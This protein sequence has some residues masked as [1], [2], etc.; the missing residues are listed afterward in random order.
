MNI[1]VDPSKIKGPYQL[2]TVFLIAVESILGYWMIRI[3]DD[4]SSERIVPGI[5]VTIIFIIFLIIT[6]KIRQTDSNGKTTHYP[7]VN[8]KF[9]ISN[10]T[11]NLDSERCT[12]KIRKADGED[13]S[14]LANPV[15]EQGGWQIIIPQNVTS[16]SDT[17]ELKLIETSGKAWTISPFYPH[18]TKQIARDEDEEQ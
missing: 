4:R 15:M 17:I 3:P 16:D 1:N 7:K 10:L 11:V 5:L 6:L 12:Y 18:V 2:L 13:E 8:V 14:G 9:P